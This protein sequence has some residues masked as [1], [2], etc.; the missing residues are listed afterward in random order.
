LSEPTFVAVVTGMSGAGKSTVLHAFEDLTYFCVDNLPIPVIADTLEACERG[1]VRR[2]ALGIDVR[3]RSFLERAPE[4]LR[5][6][7]EPG[8]REVQIV[9]LDAADEALLRRFSSTRRPHPMRRE[10]ERSGS[11]AVAVLDGITA[12]RGWLAPLRAVASHVIDTTAMSVHDLRREIL[13]LYGPGSGAS[14]GMQTRI[15]SFGFKYGTPADA[16]LV[17]DVRFLDNPYFVENLRALS[18]QDESVRRYVLDNPDS[19]EFLKL[20]EDLLTFS[21]PR[22]EREGKSYLTIALGCTGGRHRS[23]ALT[24]ALAARLTE[25]TR[26]SIETVHRDMDRDTLGGQGAGW[27][28]SEKQKRGQTGS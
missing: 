8:R 6:I 26:F 25:N 15:V 9:F 3:V 28:A 23:V 13:V 14:H 18:G 11:R 16:D 17:L 10:L 24:E 19:V 1:G 7:H 27:S 4:V 2:I 5:S 22:Y 20:A 12:E 21:L